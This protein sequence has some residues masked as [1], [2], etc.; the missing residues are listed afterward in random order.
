MGKGKGAGMRISDIAAVVPEELDAWFRF[1]FVKDM[2]GRL[3]LAVRRLYWKGRFKSSSSFT[4]YPRCEIEAPQNMAL[5]S[6]CILFEECRLSAQSGG[7]I[8]I[9]SGTVFN[10]N[11]FVNAAEGGRISI[12]KNVIVGPRTTMRASNHAYADKARLI[13]EQGHMPGEIVIGDDVWIGAHA[14][15]LPGARVGSGAV[16]AAGAVVVKEVPPYSLS[17][18][19]PAKVIRENCRK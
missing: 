16:I 1:L 11:V 12:G 8:D 2:P 6:G 9:G 4:V 18:G 3:G 15:I 17:G 7:A 5:G 14:L 19:I 13:S 10:S